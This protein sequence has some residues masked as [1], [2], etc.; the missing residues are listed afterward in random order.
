VTAA[1]LSGDQ[2]LYIKE[3]VNLQHM[4][5]LLFVDFRNP[6]QFVVPAGGLQELSGVIHNPCLTQFVC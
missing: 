4:L 5:A 6:A 2:G 3:K 1:D